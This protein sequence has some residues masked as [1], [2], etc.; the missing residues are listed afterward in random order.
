MTRTRTG[1]I[2]TLLAVALATVLGFPA[3]AQAAPGPEVIPLPDGFSPEGVATG[4]GNRVFAGSLRDGDIWRGDLSTG[5]GAVL[6]DAPAGRTAVGIKI[7]RE[8]HRVIVAG[9][10]TG[11]AFVYDSRNGRDLGEVTLT[12]ETDTFI[13]DV[14]LTDRGAWFT[15]SRQPSLY[16]LPL[17]PNGSFGPVRTL[18]LKGPAADM[19]G[20]FNLNGIAAKRD[21]SRLV[22]GHSGRSELIRVNP[23]TGA[24]RTIDLGGPSMPNADGLLLVGRRLWVTQNFLNQISEVRLSPVLRS[25]EIVEVLT[26]DNFRIPTTIARKGDK[27]VAVNARFDL[28]IPGPLDAEYELVVLDR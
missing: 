15:D 25:G 10:A 12:T 27:L 28:G 23:W 14:A 1:T 21:G 17:R 9:G 13:N 19:P 8:L 20:Q 11:K 18:A 3:V 22:V 2:R 26:N 24:S 5:Q 16:F 4:A 6:V 7:D